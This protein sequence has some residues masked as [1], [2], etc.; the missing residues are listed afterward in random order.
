MANGVTTRAEAE[1]TSS[2]NVKGVEIK[3]S[4]LVFDS[5]GGWVFLLGKPLLKVLR[6]VHDYHEDTIKISDDKMYTML[7]NQYHNPRYLQ[8]VGEQKLTLNVKQVPQSRKHKYSRWTRAQDKPAEHDKSA[9]DQY[10]T[11]DNSTKELI[12]TAY[13]MQA[14]KQNLTMPFTRQ[15]SPFNQQQVEYIV[16]NVKIG[17][18]ITQDEQAQVETLI[19]EYA[20]VFTCSLSEVLLIPDTRV[21]LNVPRDAR[22]NTNIWQWP[23]SP[24]QKQ[25]IHKWVKQML[26]ANM[27]E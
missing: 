6:A 16:R 20:D 17:D 24:P 27:I 3:G 10:D 22:F 2:V 8:M 18:N 23:L 25:Y 15:T 12:A 5:S 14:E 9:Q 26:D 4:F 13:A 1:W 19:T 7:T 11:A 21:D